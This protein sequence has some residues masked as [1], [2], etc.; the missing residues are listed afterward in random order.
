MAEAQV[1]D[2]DDPNQPLITQDD[3][4]EDKYD[5]LLRRMRE[6]REEWD[7]ARKEL[8][9]TQPFRPGQ[10]ST[11]Y[12]DGE[13]VSMQTTMQEES[14]GP[15]YAETSFGGGPTIDEISSR[16]EKLKK[17]RNDWDP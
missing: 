7:R 12:H 15:S 14:G 16:L 9:K 4:N 8:N 6:S 13:Q 3:D 10:M 1:G 5:V 2:Y 17:K 11:P